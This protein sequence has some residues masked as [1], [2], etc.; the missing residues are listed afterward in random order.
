MAFQGWPSSKAAGIAGICFRHRKSSTSSNDLP[1]GT[2]HLGSPLIYALSLI[3]PKILGG[4]MSY[5]RDRF[6]CRGTQSPRSGVCAELG[7]RPLRRR[8][9]LRAQQRLLVLCSTI[10]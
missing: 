5:A 3:C 8:A 10:I 6:G 1:F 4:M 2:D 7:R 9:R